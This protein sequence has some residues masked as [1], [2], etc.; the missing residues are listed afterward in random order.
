MS[1]YDLIRPAL[2]SL[3]PETAHRL[4]VKA[5]A[6][7]AYPRPE[8]PAPTLRRK[9][10]GLDFPNPVGIAAGFDKN[11]EVPDAL[12]ALGFG[13]VEI[14]TITPRPQPGNP[15]PRVFRLTD[16]RAMINRLG[17]NSEGFD[18]VHRRL[19]ARSPKRGIVGVNVG[20]NR[21]SADRAADYAAGIARFVDVADYLAV[22]VS[23]PNTKGLRDLQED[24]ALRTLLSRVCE[25]REAAIRR[26]P[27]L[28]KIAPDLDDAAIA[29]TVDIAIEA[30]IEGMIVSNTTVTRNTVADDPQAQ[31][32][33]G[34]SGEP[35]F[36]LSTRVLAKVR[37]AAGD[38]LVLVGVGG[39]DSAER[40]L[41][42]LKAGADLIQLY[43]GIV[44]AGPGLAGQI[45]AELPRLLER[46][47]VNRIADIVGRDAADWAAQAT[48]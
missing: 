3:D 27:I 43:T 4:A 31:E 46:E 29:A 28:L 45:V 41:V 11:A 39:V 13:F 38:R 15:K 33:G 35:L 2:F 37:Q 40:A 23:S 24:T 36:A 9:L 14:G 20:T 18:A 22:N 1:V 10:L 21:D 32:A 47:G 7:G 42:K 17:F 25:A 6:A 8:P 16:H 34:L 19:A 5:L 48:G 30:G 12:L 44:Y 26:P